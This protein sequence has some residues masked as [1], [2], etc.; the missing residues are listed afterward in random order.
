MGVRRRAV[1]DGSAVPH[2]PTRQF[3]VIEMKRLAVVIGLFGGVGAERSITG[4]VRQSG[5]GPMRI[6]KRTER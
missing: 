4:V 1:A 5:M 2:Q 6:G 3:L